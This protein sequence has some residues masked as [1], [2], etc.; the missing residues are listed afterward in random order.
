MLRI[1]LPTDI[2]MSVFQFRDSLIT[3][4][5]EQR[6]LGY[7][8]NHLYPDWDSSVL[9]AHRALMIPDCFDVVSQ[10]F[11]SSIHTWVVRTQYHTILIDTCVGNDKIRSLPRFNQLNLPFLKQLAKAGVS[12]ESVDYV[13]CT[14]LHADHCGWNTQLVDGRWV[15][16]F[17]NAKYVFSRL[18]YEYWLGQISDDNFNANVFEDSVLP[19][20]EQG[21]AHIIDSTDA[22]AD[23]LLIH[24]T[25]GHSP[26]HITFE[27]L[28]GG[29]SCGGGLFS[30]D[31][32]HQP[33]QVF[34]PSWNSC[35][36]ADPHR[37]VASR[38]WL[39]E[40]AAENRST[41]FTAHF[42]NTSAGRV[43]RVGNG[44]SWQ[45]IQEK[46]HA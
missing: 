1:S 30:G 27:L 21:Q 5:I 33:L 6:G 9:E 8:P 20:I 3:Q 7:C 36:C 16:T 26:G 41:V 32:M 31:S 14:H 10:R 42:A 17:P 2:A 24:P 43:A 18:E 38:R 40:Y 13:M 11:I 19:V 25:F 29:H 4:V 45:F 35:F 46:D 34:N 44:F 15:P 23:T 39:L 12:V 37:S 22:I 28:N